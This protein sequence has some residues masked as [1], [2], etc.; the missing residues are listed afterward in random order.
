MVASSELLMR[1]MA[2]EID[3]L[4]EQRDELLE[5]AKLILSNKRGED[6]WLI[7]SIHCRRLEEVIA[8]ANNS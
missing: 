8:K 5:A 6:D 1:K 3:N 4:Q 7:L 2:V